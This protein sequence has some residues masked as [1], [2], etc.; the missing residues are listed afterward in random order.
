MAATSGGNAC[1]FQADA[2][3]VQE[4]HNKANKKKG[5]LSH[6]CSVG[7]CMVARGALFGK[8]RAKLSSSTCLFKQS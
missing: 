2:F 6:R 3:I 8:S 1:K 4:K 5:L 7:Y